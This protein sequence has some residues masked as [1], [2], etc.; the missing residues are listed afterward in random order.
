MCQQL[1]VCTS[2]ASAT[3]GLTACL[4]PALPAGLPALQGCGLITYVDRQRAAVAI[5]Q[6]H[7]KYVFPGSDCPIVVE[8]MDL[9]KQ[10]PVGEDAAACRKLL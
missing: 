8:W 1:C 3:A 7:G 6:L 2:H 10:R 9:K 5:A 4:R